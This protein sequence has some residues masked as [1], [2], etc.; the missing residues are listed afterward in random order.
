VN[1][2]TKAILKWKVPSLENEGQF[3]QL[4]T[5]SHVGTSNKNEI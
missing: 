3:G 1:H 2:S 4:V 5:K